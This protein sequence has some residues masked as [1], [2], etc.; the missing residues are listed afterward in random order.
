MKFHFVSS[1]GHNNV[2]VGCLCVSLLYIPCV[3]LLFLC[4]HVALFFLPYLL[5]NFSACILLFRSRHD[6]HQTLLF[7]FFPA[8]FGLVQFVTGI[9]CVDLL[10]T[11]LLLELVNHPLMVH[12]LTAGLC[13]SRCPVC[14]SS[15]LKRYC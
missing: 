12:S 5:S 15:Q 8:Y 7:P 13:C 2:L 10:L 6:V 4:F 3:L 9:P 1:L 11:S 14:L